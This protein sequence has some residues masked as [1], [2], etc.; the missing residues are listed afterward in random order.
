MGQVHETIES[1]LRDWIEA[2]RLFFVATAPL[3]PEHHLNVSPKGMDTFRVL[4]PR[5]VAYLDLTGSGVETIAHL[6]ENG[7]IVVM[8]C[9]LEG[10]PKIVRLHGRGLVIAVGEPEYQQYARHFPKHQ[11]GRAVIVVEI[12]RISDSCGYGV[13]KYEFLEERPTLTK[14]CEAKGET[15]L[16]DYRRNKNSTSIDGIPGLLHA[17]KD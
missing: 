5:R 14:W 11:G 1:E 15:G 7:R 3:S 9:A 2:Q 13:P 10:P 12:S 16:A 6:Q 4:G 8:F 17:P